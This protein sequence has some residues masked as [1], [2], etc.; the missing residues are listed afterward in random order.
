MDTITDTSRASSHLPLYHWQSVDE[1][2]L[3]RGCRLV[4]IEL[5]DEAVE[6]PAFP[7]PLQAAYVLGPERGVLSTGVIAHHVVRIPTAFSLNV[8]TAGAI[9][10]YDRL[11]SLGRFASR[12]VAGGSLPE[13]VT[14]HVQGGPRRRKRLI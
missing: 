8:A 3:P 12:P 11:R 10:M 6:L 9:V 1:L 4:G 14:E 2:R 5:L 13:P 7:H